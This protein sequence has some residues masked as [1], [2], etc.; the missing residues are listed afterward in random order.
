[1]KTLGGPFVFG[2]VAD[3]S[4]HVDVVGDLEEESHEYLRSTPVKIVSGASNV[5][6]NVTFSSESPVKRSAGVAFVIIEKEKLLCGLNQSEK[7]RKPRKPN[8]GEGSRM[9]AS[10]GGLTT[11]IG[12]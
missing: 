1:M 5:V 11:D 12:L 6:H 10:T 7:R 4:I 9:T 3:E 8:D 2:G